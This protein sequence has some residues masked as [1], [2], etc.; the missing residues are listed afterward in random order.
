MDPGGARFIVPGAAFAVAD[1]FGHHFVPVVVP[2]IAAF[3]GLLQIETAAALGKAV[4]Q[5]VPDA[6]DVDR[7]L[8]DVTR[9]DHP[10]GNRAVAVAAVRFACGLLMAEV[11][12]NMVPRFA[13]SF[14]EIDGQP[15]LSMIR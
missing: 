10:A 11:C 3:D 1:W 15:A 9:P 5:P 13:E 14:Q 4:L 12:R 2:G 8:C 6:H 7:P